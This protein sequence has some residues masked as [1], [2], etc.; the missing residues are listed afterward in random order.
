MTRDE[1]LAEQ[2]RLAELH[3]DAFLVEFLGAQRAGL[4]QERL[5]ELIDAGLLDDES[6]KGLKAGGTDLDMYEFLLVAGD[7]MGTA[8]DATRAQMRTW[9]IERWAPLVEVRAVDLRNRRRDELEAVGGGR[10]A[11]PPAPPI[12]RTAPMPIEPPTWMSPAESAGYVR[13][14]TRARRVLSRSW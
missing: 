4:S 13:A 7:I 5:G 14:L 3:H 2:R 1:L 9:G 12:E 11:L 10:G 6:M 8:D